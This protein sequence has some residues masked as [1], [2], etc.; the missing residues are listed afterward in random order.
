MVQPAQVQS[1]TQ[2][3]K[4]TVV[5]IQNKPQAKPAYNDDLIN[6][7]LGFGKPKRRQVE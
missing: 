6:D 3:L 7:L 1:H 2:G 4:N 5:N